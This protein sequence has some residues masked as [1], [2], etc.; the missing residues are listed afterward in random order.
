[1]YG[2]NIMHEKVLNK[3]NAAKVSFKILK[4]YH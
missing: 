4:T 3:T 1:M 2:F